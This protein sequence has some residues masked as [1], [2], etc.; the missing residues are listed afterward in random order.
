MVVTSER[1]QSRLQMIEPFIRSRAIY[2]SAHSHVFCRILHQFQLCSR[3]SSP[4][5][6]TFW[7]IHGKKPFFFFFYTTKLI[8]NWDTLFFSET[9][10]RTQRQGNQFLSKPNDFTEY[11]ACVYLR[12]FHPA[13]LFLNSVPEDWVFSRCVCVYMEKVVVVDAINLQYD[14]NTGNPL[15]RL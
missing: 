3:S 11:T 15:Q 12:S 8:P 5:F 4:H 6:E 7:Y 14:E 10:P 9:K 13:P 1:G 2:S